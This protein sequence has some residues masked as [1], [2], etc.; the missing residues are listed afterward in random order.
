MGYAVILSSNTATAPAPVPQREAPAGILNGVNTVFTL[1]FTPNPA[2][3]LLL[4]LNGV[5]QN[6]GSGS[7]ISGADYSIS[8]V[9]ITFTVAPRASDWMMAFYTH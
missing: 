1:S 9:T 3:S 7:P 5:V 6:P 2:D 4:L 8:G